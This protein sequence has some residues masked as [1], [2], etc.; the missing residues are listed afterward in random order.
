M[1]HDVVNQQHLLQLE[2]EELLDPF[3]ILFQRSC[4]AT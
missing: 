4:R 3:P 2:A 1:D